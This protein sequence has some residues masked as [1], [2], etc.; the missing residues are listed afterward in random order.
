MSKTIDDLLDEIKKCDACSL[1]EEN[2]ALGIPLIRILPK[3]N[4]SVMF[5][6]RDPSPR[7]ATVVGL[8]GGKSSF[9]NEIYRIVDE[10]G[11]PDKFIYITDLCKC[12]WRTSVGTPLPGTENRPT[13][14]DR[15]VANICTQKWLFREAAIIKPNLIVAFGEEAYQLLRHQLTMPNPAPE[16]LSASKNKSVV[17]AESWFV[18]H[19]LMKINILGE[20]YPFI[21]LRHPGNSQRLTKSSEN[22]QRLYY[23]QEAT[24]VVISL[25]KELGIE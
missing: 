13:L 17:D 18:Q 4:A 10:A 3:P 5:V 7:T 23:H 1:M 21:V 15:D 8:R 11:L 25:I 14:L 2:T 24:K 20:N 12:H 19:G 6:G 9:I 22:D 16:K